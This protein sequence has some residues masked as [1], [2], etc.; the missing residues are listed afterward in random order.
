MSDFIPKAVRLLAERRRIDTA[1]AESPSAPAQ[2]AR[3]NT[4]HK[5]EDLFWQHIHAA[6][7][8]GVVSARKPIEISFEDTC[9]INFGTAP[10]L[11][12]AELLDTDGSTVS[13]DTTTL[14]MT[15]PQQQTRR[16]ALGFMEMNYSE[17]HSSNGVY[18]LE[19]WLQEMFRDCLD[20][21]A[22][23]ALQERNE[24]L[25]DEMKMIPARL[26][27][28]GIPGQ[29]VTEIM[30]AF[31]AL[32]AVQGDSMAREQHKTSVTN[33]RSYA[34]IQQRA[35]AILARAKPYITQTL[36]TEEEEPL[37]DLF[38]QYKTILFELQEN[39]ARLDAV[40]HLRPEEQTET[41]IGLLET[42]RETMTECAEE[43]GI[44]PCSVL[45]VD[46]AARICPRQVVEEELEALLMYD[47]VR[48]ADISADRLE[49][50][51]FGPLCALIVPGRGKARFSTELR[52]FHAERLNNQ[53]DDQRRYD[54]N[55]RASYPMNYIVVPNL[56]AP[57][58]ALEQM[59]DAFLEYKSIACPRSFKQFTNEVRKNFPI[60]H[61]RALGREGLS[62]AFRKELAAYLGGFVRWA[63]YGRQMDLPKLP[64]FIEWARTRIKR[65]EML[66]PPRYRCIL[67][68]F[69]DA[70]PARR[71]SIY[72]KHMRDRYTTE[73]VRMSLHLLNR[74]IDEAIQAARTLPAEV[75]S[76]RYFK[77][78]V[79]SARNSER[80]KSERATLTFLEKFI[81]SEA[82]V[83]R[84]YL[85]TESR[86]SGEMEMLQTHAIRELG[87]QL[88]AE[89]AAASVMRRQLEQNAQREAFA[90]Q[91]ID[92]DLLGL[93]FY[94]ERNFTAARDELSAYLERLERQREERNRNQRTFDGS[95]LQE[96]LGHRASRR[97]ES[98]A[99][100]KR[101]DTRIVGAEA[102]VSIY[103]DDFVY[104]N[105]GM[106]ALK[107]EDRRQASDCFSRFCLWTAQNNWH[108]Y[109]EFAREIN[110]EIEDTLKKTTDEAG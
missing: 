44:P 5:M 39:R 95:S 10:G 15:P 97:Q 35:D 73:R 52:Q 94:V 22:M 87:H 71:E 51:K 29:L 101:H 46:E 62:N 61:K 41:L 30:Q 21:D 105:L 80:W 54:L 6:I 49:T 68:D 67:E 76:N 26:V 4:A 64:E 106:L 102:P 12:D 66:I 74:S 82:S 100:I 60:I 53:A 14:R 55:R 40:H 88:K 99:D 84:I 56:T 23:D 85:K 57:E 3:W 13:S 37:D 1:I 72:R 28:L 19:P 70:S 34:M 108:L 58:N 110:N 107:L 32:Q 45:T 83:R 16:R 92:R 90:N 47:I 93:L 7:A 43:E 59:A 27:S 79:E 38:H 25:Q 91:R 65:P 42:L 77:K 69:A 31:R 50:R 36:G 109:G 75:R 18:N 2:A 24:T 48:H 63:K 96:M 86:F 9:F 20:V 33:A 103:E 104:Y 11:I 8:E 78:A 81:A 98:R 17:L 89:E